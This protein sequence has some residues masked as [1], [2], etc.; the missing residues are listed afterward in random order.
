MTDPLSVSV[1][2]CAYTEDRWQALC[3]AVRSALGQDFPADE[4]IVVID[5]NPRLLYR[6]A[7]ALPAEVRVLP[8]AC[9]KGL[10]GARNTAIAAARG[11]ILAFLDDDAAA[12]PDWLAALLPHFDDPEVVGVGGYARP[13]WPA[14]RRRPPTLPAA[15]R[16]AGELDW[17][18][19]CTYRGQ[20]VE[21]API[22]NLMGCNMAVRSDVFGRAGGFHEGL[23]RIGRT[24]LGCEETE[25][26]IRVSQRLP[27]S[28]FVF[29]PAARVRHQ[30]SPDRLTWRYLVHRSY[31]EGVSKAAVTRLVGAQDGLSTERGYLTGVLPRAVARESRRMSP[32]GVLSAAAV[33]TAASATTAGYLRGKFASPGTLVDGAPPEAQATRPPSVA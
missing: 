29:E 16:S 4:V 20:P 30:V 8:N 28:R 15:G 13:S 14:G 6:A 7:Q 18:V 9:G 10:S 32:S 26:C 5:H 31:A 22:R 11:Q 2:V 27:G 33:V 21:A 19:G 23:G 25:W 1:V 17:V 3:A 24:P 12:E